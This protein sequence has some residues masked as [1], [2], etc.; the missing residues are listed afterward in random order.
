MELW[1][2]ALFILLCI[3]VGAV[4]FVGL[5]RLFLLLDRQRPVASLFASVAPSSIGEEVAPVIEQAA[6]AVRVQVELMDPK[7]VAE[8][9]GQT[10]HRRAAS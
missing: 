6:S 3:I 1:E 10:H 8:V 9:D 7:L 4:G 2:V 5:F